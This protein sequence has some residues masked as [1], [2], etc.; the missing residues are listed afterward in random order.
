MT[1]KNMTDTEVEQYIGDLQ[2]RLRLA[3]VVL[4]EVM[5]IT[6]IDEAHSRVKAMQEVSASVDMVQRYIT[7]RIPM[8][9][10]VE[11]PTGFG[12]Y[13]I[14]LGINQED[15]NE[16]SFMSEEDLA[17]ADE[18]G[19]SPWCYGGVHQGATN[20]VVKYGTDERVFDDKNELITI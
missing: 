7:P 1:T 5:N 12:F 14:C 8:W 16:I 17:Q 4:D 10:G 9:I 20:M 3:E 13:R 6:N 18:H 19:E 15:E 11:I 2:E